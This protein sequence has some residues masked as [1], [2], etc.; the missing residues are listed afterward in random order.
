MGNSTVKR[1][2]ISLALMLQGFLVLEDSLQC[3]GRMG[4]ER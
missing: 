2:S 3:A 4:M 1:A